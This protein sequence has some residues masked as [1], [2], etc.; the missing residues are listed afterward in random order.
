MLYSPSYLPDFVHFSD[1]V[2]VVVGRLVVG[3]E[4]VPP[5]VVEARYVRHLSP[6]VLQLMLYWPSNFPDLVH[7]SDDVPSSPFR[8]RR[9]RTC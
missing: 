2:I 6:H 5:V 7:E 4:A 9:T 8:P 1:V 3:L